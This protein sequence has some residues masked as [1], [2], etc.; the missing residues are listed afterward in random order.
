MKNVL[1]SVLFAALVLL[2]APCADAASFKAK[3]FDDLVAQAQQI[4]VG[5]SIGSNAHYTERGL[6][7]TDYSFDIIETVKGATAT[8][9]GPGPGPF[10]VTLLGGKV[11]DVELAIS[12]AP[13]FDIGVK[14]FLFVSGNGSTMFPL[15]GGH[16][17][18]YQVRTDPAT[19][20]ENLHDYDGN[21]LSQLP[22][23]PTT[24]AQRSKPQ[25]ADTARTQAT[26]GLATDGLA[27]KPLSLSTM[28]AEIR[29]RLGAI[30]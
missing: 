25:N 27:A 22:R 17:G 24:A 6:I 19:G 28:K 10:I 11:G 9:P 13:K 3:S 15:V 4:F 29:N 20:Q 23:T 30:Q 18:I 5:T 7:V 21:A 1:M 26:D 2:F 12:G 8:S 16:Q 14:Y